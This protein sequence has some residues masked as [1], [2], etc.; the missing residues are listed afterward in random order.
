MGANLVGIEAVDVRLPFLDQPGGELVH[1]LEVVGREVQRVPGKT[2]PPDVFFDAVDV[3]DVFL[4]GVR[5]VE[6]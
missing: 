2:E 6:T 1:P 4:G 5:V 3:L